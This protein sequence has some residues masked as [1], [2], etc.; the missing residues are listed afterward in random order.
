MGISPSTVIM[1]ILYYIVP[2]IS[3]GRID[4]LV[5]DILCNLYIV[6]DRQMCYNNSCKGT[7]AVVPAPIE[8]GWNAWN[9]WQL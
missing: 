5:P 7:V 8:R 1:I 4:K 3:I 9:I 2:D 6:P